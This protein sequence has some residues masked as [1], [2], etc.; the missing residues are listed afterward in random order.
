MERVFFLTF[1]CIFQIIQHIQSSQIFRREIWHM[2]FEI[3]RK[4][5]L[6]KGMIMHYIHCHV[7]SNHL[8][9]V[10]CAAKMK[11]SWR[12][13]HAFAKTELGDV[14]RT[15]CTKLK[16]VCLTVVT[17]RVKIFLF[18]SGPEW[19]DNSDL[20]PVVHIFIKR[21]K[22]RERLSH[23]VLPCLLNFDIHGGFTVGLLTF[24]FYQ[25]V[26]FPGNKYMCLFVIYPS[27]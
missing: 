14:W 6:N 24:E 9:R 12:S 16:Y 10:F 4:I 23:W 22:K 19:V 8:S 15:S 21:K 27:F 18:S 20:S 2:K 1:D 11:I 7:I 5:P 17:G 13:C 26:G 25:M 3:K